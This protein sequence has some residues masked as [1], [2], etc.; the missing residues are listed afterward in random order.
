MTNKLSGE[1]GLVPASRGAP[2]GL[3]RAAMREWAEELVGRD[4]AE[5]VDSAA[6]AGS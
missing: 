2:A 4:R 5:G 6:R 3:D 1:N